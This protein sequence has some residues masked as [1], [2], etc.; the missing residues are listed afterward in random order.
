M[1]RLI[2]QRKNERLVEV[3]G[4]GISA[5]M[6]AAAFFGILLLYDEMGLPRCCLAFD[7]REPPVVMMGGSRYRL[8]S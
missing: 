7:A 2:E 8:G 3:P 6:A 4:M 5:T 1:F